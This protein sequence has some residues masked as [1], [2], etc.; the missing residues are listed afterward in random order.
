VVAGG[1]AG[2]RPGRHQ[3]CGAERRE[4]PP[5]PLHDES[6]EHRREQRVGDDLE[7]DADERHRARCRRFERHRD[8]GEDQPRHAHRDPDAAG[9]P[10]LEPC[11]AGG[12]GRLVLGCE[13]LDIRVDA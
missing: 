6:G 1:R 10:L 11:R 4:Q 13:L 7:Q 3:R 2:D 9:D 12:T 5:A 8:L